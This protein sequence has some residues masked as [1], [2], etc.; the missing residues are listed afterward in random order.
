MYMELTLKD[1]SYINKLLNKYE[2]KEISDF[3]R[4]KELDRKATFNSKMFAYI[5][6]T[7]SC[8]I[9]GF[10]MCVA[11]KQILNIA[12][13]GVVVGLIGMFLMIITYPI[14]KNMSKKSKDKYASEII[15]LSNQ[16]LDE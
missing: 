13:L 1:K 7:I 2:T 10:G 11:M 8:L 3:Q 9:F 5:F 16:L 15:E 12:W 4:L 14:Y 6:G